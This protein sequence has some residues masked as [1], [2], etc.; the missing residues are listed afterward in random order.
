MKRAIIFGSAPVSDWSFLNR[1]LTPDS[2]VIC[3][4]GG[5]LA[6][7]RLGLEPDWYVGDN[8]SGGSVGRCPADVL[9]SEKDVTDLDMAVSRAIREGCGQIVL[10]GCTGGRQDHHLSA[11]GQLERIHR[12]GA[13]GVLVN[14]C[15][16]IRLL[17]P[18]VHTIKAQDEFQYFGLVP[19]DAHL[20]GVTITGAKYEVSDQTFCRWESLGVSNQ[21]LPGRDCVIRVGSGVGLL[22]LSN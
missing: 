12:A 10:C 17:Y 21:P 15:N 16:E 3:A 6:A 9:P 14:E 5:L 18:G 1:W 22:I 7:Q 20:T 13:E 11:I 19:L 8:D 4:D 2:V